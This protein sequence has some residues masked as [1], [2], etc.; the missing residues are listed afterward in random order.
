MLDTQYNCLS[1]IEL[2]ELEK[3]NT[4]IYKYKLYIEHSIFS[5]NISR[6]KD[7]MKQ[8]TAIEVTT[9]SQHLRLLFL[10]EKS[11]ISRQKLLA[12]SKCLQQTQ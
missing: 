8:I 1:L 5:D 2:Q 7:S 3:Y 10:L 9:S 11:K 4:S 12:A 6:T